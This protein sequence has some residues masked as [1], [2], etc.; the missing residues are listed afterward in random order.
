MTTDTIDPVESVPAT[1]V[2]IDALVVGSRLSIRTSGRVPYHFRVTERSES[3][4]RTIAVGDLRG[5]LYRSRR[6]AALVGADTAEGVNRSAI[7]LG[8]GAVFLVD[9]VAGSSADRIVTSAIL[10]LR[11]DDAVASAA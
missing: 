3:P 9:P 11:V 8:D 6:R 10:E 1:T 4:E 2:P 7:R 5:G